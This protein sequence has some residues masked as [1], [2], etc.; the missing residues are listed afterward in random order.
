MTSF[1]IAYSAFVSIFR[2]AVFY[3]ALVLGLVVLMDW[4]VRTRRISPF[5]GTA[6]FFRKTVDPWM[7]PVER[8][9]VRAGGPREA[10]PN[11]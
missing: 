5:T 3:V 11:A 8:M 1:L 6:R 4:A 7:V 9:V 10:Q 2:T